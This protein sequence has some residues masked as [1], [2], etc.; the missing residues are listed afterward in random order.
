VG[1]EREE[2]ETKKT[3]MAKKNEKKEQ[4]TPT[5]IL[6]PS[7]GG[8]MTRGNPSKCQKRIDHKGTDTKGIPWIL[9]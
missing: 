9:Y 4:G 7:Q 5:Q 8:A 2:R 6:A 3:I 1:A